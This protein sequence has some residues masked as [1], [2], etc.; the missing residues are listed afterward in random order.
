MENSHSPPCYSFKK[1][2][3]DCVIPKTLLT[4]HHSP[5]I[6]IKTAVYSYHDTNK[7]SQTRPPKKPLKIESQSFSSL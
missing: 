6:A 5:K 3:S 1:S 4:Y 7:Q 2:I